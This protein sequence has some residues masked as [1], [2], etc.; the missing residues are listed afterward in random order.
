VRYLTVSKYSLVGWFAGGLNISV[1]ARVTFCDVHQYFS[2][3]D[4][5]CRGRE[6]KYITMDL[7]EK[8]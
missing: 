1:A 6:N 2:S 4:L 7:H 8:H 3:I 5:I